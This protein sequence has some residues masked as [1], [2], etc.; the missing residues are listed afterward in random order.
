MVADPEVSQANAVNTMVDTIIAPADA[1]GA[2]RAVPTWGLALV[3]AIV[4]SALGTYLSAPAMAHGFAGTFAHMAASDPKLAALDPDKLQSIIAM[5]QK[6]FSFG[7]IVT[8]FVVP[9]FALIS[10]LVM[11]VF[12]KVG[13]GD[14]SF[15]KYWAAAC[16]IAI[17]SGIAAV[18]LGIIT[19]ARGAN[20]FPT[21][22]AVQ[23]SLPS[24]ALL[25]PGAGIKLMTFLATITPF[26]LWSAALVALAVMRIGRARPF[27]AWVCGALMLIVPAL[28]AAV[29]AK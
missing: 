20:S 25:A 5:Q 17:V 29:N 6:F 21:M 9:F 16:N 13:R 27:A 19:M 23:S 26:S 4:L 3:V 18:I 11:L 1:F 14:G 28:L 7:W 12:D 22:L 2:I 8:I 24:A 15:G 10:A